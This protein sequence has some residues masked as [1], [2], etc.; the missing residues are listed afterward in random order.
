MKHKQIELKFTSSP[1][2]PHYNHIKNIRNI[3]RDSPFEGIVRLLGGYVKHQ[4]FIDAFKEIYND[5]FTFTDLVYED[6]P[7]LKLINK[8]KK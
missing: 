5:S 1:Y 4:S 8:E 6:D 3:F 2:E 7:F